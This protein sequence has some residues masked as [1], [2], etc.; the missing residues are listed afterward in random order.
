MWDRRVG[1]CRNAFR[2]T[3]DPSSK[4]RLLAGCYLQGCWWSATG[5]PCPS[6]NCSTQK[7]PAKGT[8]SCNSVKWKFCI[9]ENVKLS[10]HSSPE[11]SQNCKSPGD[12]A[13]YII[14]IFPIT[15]VS[16]PKVLELPH[17]FQ[18]VF[19]N[20]QSAHTHLLK[21]T[22]F[23]VLR[24]IKMH[25]DSSTW[26]WTRL[27]LSCTNWTK[28]LALLVKRTLLFWYSQRLPPQG[29]S[30]ADKSCLCTPRMQKFERIKP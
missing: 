9:P 16:D 15:Q 2:W 26:S 6:D 29:S 13:A 5:C 11:F 4:A 27:A 17:L 23:C 21:K 1:I 10:D 14:Y 30:F 28:S 12:V 22:M 19:P 24:D 7:C 8:P 25:S 20:I 18:W 3:T